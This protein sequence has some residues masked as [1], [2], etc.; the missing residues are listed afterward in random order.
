MTPK[1]SSWTNS[2][3]ILDIL[4]TKHRTISEGLT[5]PWG[6]GAVGRHG[7]V[8]PSGKVA[9]PEGCP[10]GHFP[11]NPVSSCITI[12]LQSQPSFQFQKSLKGH[13]PE[14]L[15][16]SCTHSYNNEEFWKAGQRSH[17]F[18][19][20]PFTWST[21]ICILPKPVH[22]GWKTPGKQVFSVL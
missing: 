20:T 17:H 21:F 8:R 18:H 4:G 10:Y 14:S 15:V 22:Q 7:V 1:L 19:F 16:P 5:T 13:H 6:P 11:H 3:T 2:V 12:L 9:G